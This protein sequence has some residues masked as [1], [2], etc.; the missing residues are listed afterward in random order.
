MIRTTLVRAVACT[1]ALLLLNPVTA[2]AQ[3]SRAE[4]IAEQQ[5]EKAQ[6]LAPEEAG[7]FERAIVRIM[8]SP[9]LAGN[10]GFYPWVGS[11][12][13]GSGL[14]GG[15]GYLGRYPRAIS[16]T[17]FAGASING[18]HRI[19]GSFTGPR[20]A[21]RT[22]RPYVRGSYIDAKRVAFFGLG[23][24]TLAGDRVRY[25]FTPKSVSADLA[26]TPSSW[27]ELDGGF[28]FLAFGTEAGLAPASL[29]FTGPAFGERVRYQVTR[30]SA[31]VD[32][33]L[34]P[35]YSTSGTLLR[36]AHELYDERR[37]LP[38]DFRLTEL[39]AVQL[40]PLLHEQFV[41]AFRGLTT[42][43]HS[44][45]DDDVPLPLLPHIGGGN[46]VRGLQNRRYQDRNRAVVTAEYR[47]RPSRSIDMALF[48][49]AGQVAAERR[50]LRLKEFD[51]AWGIGMRLHGPT[52]TAL[53]I[54]G[55]R[56]SQ[57]WVLI[58]AGGPPF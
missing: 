50:Q 20:F 49:D 53:R 1:A 40:V 44:D 24:E 7:R 35:G 2:A 18:S 27:F 28:E 42:F 33:R 56:S 12:F 16:V 34:S 38:Y 5:A 39:E 55:A 32:T 4:I 30:G 19:E 9:L 25:E 31:A 43:T 41:L 23:S 54:E 13:P 11:V 36:A 51:T 10:G 37:D 52:F 29:L 26:F 45:G 57:G 15:V 48:V 47:W 22:L 58:F 14:A 21:N 17:T 6:H 3:N 8:G 46:T